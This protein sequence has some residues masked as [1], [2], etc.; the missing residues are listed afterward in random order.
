M[1]TICHCYPIPHVTPSACF[2]T[3]ESL[4]NSQNKRTLRSR[5]RTCGQSVSRHCTTAQ[6]TAA[7][8]A[9][10]AAFPATHATL[11]APVGP[12]VTA[13]PG[14][15]AANGFTPPIAA[16]V[17]VPLPG[18]AAPVIPAV[19]APA[20][21]GAMAPA[22]PIAAPVGP[23][24]PSTQASAAQYKLLTE[25]V[26]INPQLMWSDQQDAHRFLTALESILEFSPVLHTHWT[27][28][29]P[30]M[31]PG[32]FELERTWV[33]NNIMTPLLSWNAAKAAFI[34]HF[35]RGDYM[36]G[37]RWLYD[38]RQQ[39]HETVQEYSRR[40]QTI[41]TQLGYADNDNQSIYRFMGGLSLG[42]QQKMTA[43]KLSMR[44]VGAA[45]AWDF[46]SLSAAAQ[47][48]I[49]IGTQP[50]Y[51]QQAPTTN[52]PP[53]HLRHSALANPIHQS[54]TTSSSISSSTSTSSRPQTR[55]NTRKRKETAGS[56]TNEEKKCIYHPNAKGHIT[57]DCRKNPDNKG[58]VAR[59]NSPPKTQTTTITQTKVTN[60]QPASQQTPTKPSSPTDLSTVR[61][62]RC[63]QYGHLANACPQKTGV[64]AI[65]IKA[66]GRRSAARRSRVKFKQ[67]MEEDDEEDEK[68]GSSSVPTTQSNVQSS[69]SESK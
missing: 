43:H 66:R 1:V 35:Q 19:V 33:R 4:A 12:G 3:R 8:N 44:T 37:L 21:V 56:N 27:S 13:P 18:P 61:C 48:A 20:P 39:Q 9:H 51:T 23:N 54:T 67:P 36:D 41:T 32:Q 6:A 55:F 69:T 64:K 34:G 7:F 11:N 30:M 10:I 53:L 26:K 60:N 62:F 65:G 2:E 28:L 15:A 42:V 14:Y 17:V 29:I 59:G 57:E 25:M 49:I 46:V 47:L 31:I 38:C 40:F 68:H 5:C 63:Q 52:T 22:A 45:P 58:K 24:I 50:I 16:A